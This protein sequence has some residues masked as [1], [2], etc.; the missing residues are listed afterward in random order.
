MASQCR[1]QLAQAIHG[2]L[3]TQSLFVA[4]CAQFDAQHTDGLVHT[5][6]V[7]KYP[8]GF[9]GVAGAHQ[10]FGTGQQACNAVQR[11][12]GTDLRVFGDVLRGAGQGV[13]NGL[14]LF[15]RVGTRLLP[16]QL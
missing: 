7:L 13:T 1:L 5:F 16:L 11:L 14:L 12:A 10:L 15:Q 9:A 4:Q 2:S 3:A 6:C 8:T